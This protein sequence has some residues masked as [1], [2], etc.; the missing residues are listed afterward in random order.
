MGWFSNLFGSKKYLH[1]AIPLNIEFSDDVIQQDRGFPPILIPPVYAY[2]SIRSSGEGGFEDVE[3][4]FAEILRASDVEAYFKRSIIKKLTLFFKEG[5]DLVGRNQQ[6]VNY[7]KKRLRQIQEA[8]RIPTSRLFRQTAE[9]LITFSNCFWVV[10]RDKNKSGG[11]VYKGRD[12][13]A[14]I[15]VIPAETIK[16]KTNKRGLIVAYQQHMPDGRKRRFSAKDVIHFSIDRKS[17]FTVGTPRVIPVLDD[18][19]S[20]RRIEEN[21]E[22]L[23]Y[24]DIFPL[25]QYKVGTESR[26]ALEYPDGTTEMEEVEAKIAFM[27]PEGI[28]VTPERHDIT[29]IGAQGRALQ[30][31]G[32]LAHFKQRVLSGL[33]ISGI[34]V[35]E[36]EGASKASGEVVSQGLVDEVKDLQDLFEQQIKFNF[37]DTLLLESTFKFDVLSPDN[38]VRIVFKEIDSAAQIAAENHNSQ[39]FQ[40]NILTHG[41]ARMRIGM[42]PMSDEDWTDSFFNKV[43]VPTLKLEASMKAQAASNTSSSPDGRSINRDMPENQYK[44]KLEPL[45]SINSIEDKNKSSVFDVFKAAREDSI[46]YS[47]IDDNSTWYTVVLKGAQEEFKK[48]FNKVLARKF[49]A[50]YRSVDLSTTFDLAASVKTVTDHSNK[51]VDAVFGD[52][53]KEVVKQFNPVE[54]GSVFDNVQWRINFIYNTESNR[55]FNY[56]VL[57]ALRNNGLQ[58]VA[59]ERHS[60]TECEICDKMSGKVYD[61][62][63]LSLLNIPPHHVNC[64]CRIKR[65]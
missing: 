14:G 18:I 45:T 16:V 47:G 20:F 64:T 17:G 33:G 54:I 30:V 29:A 13:I 44:T 7:I 65:S 62:A 28:F 49:V 2:K 46:Y 4:D 41:E 60:E 25:Y 21:V 26:P 61:V 58:K 38:N 1:E 37:F 55:A 15:F 40:N 57:T 3:Y 59:I 12:P 10:V 35:G 34:D 11:S 31:E 6:T 8:T 9:D 53:K 42:D 56:G 22:M 52:I 5:Y 39:L 63:G 50:G 23:I 43:T 24:R 19:R 51:Y 32:H 36:T 48:R 27:P